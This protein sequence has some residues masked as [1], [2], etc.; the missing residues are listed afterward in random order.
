LL[1]DAGVWLTFFGVEINNPWMPCVRK[2]RYLTLGWSVSLLTSLV[3]VARWP[4]LAA[5]SE[6]GSVYA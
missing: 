3:V 4:H 1:H 6:S 2:N 5:L